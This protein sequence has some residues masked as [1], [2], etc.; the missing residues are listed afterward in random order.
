MH[1]KKL[2]Y[3]S[4]A[5]ILF[6]T[7]ASLTTRQHLH[8]RSLYEMRFAVTLSRTGLMQSTL[9]P[10]MHAATS[11]C[12]TR[13]CSLPLK[14]TQPHSLLQ[15]SRTLVLFHL[16]VLLWPTQSWTWVDIITI[17]PSCGLLMKL[18]LRCL[19][20]Q[21]MLSWLYLQQIQI[22]TQNYLTIVLEMSWSTSW[23]TWRAES[24][25]ISRCTAL[26]FKHALGC[27]LCSRQLSRWAKYCSC[28]IQPSH[29]VNLLSHD[30]TFIFTFSVYF[31]S[32]YSG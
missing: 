7:L 26:H 18:A 25:Y 10:M 3:I 27:V 19:R 28:T 1:L 20:G 21:E 29:R 5:A 13:L 30:H 2:L 4:D 31:P 12:I 24:R 6:I 16:L 17:H 23:G 15:Q 11:S 22:R 9:R 32:P 14:K 8:I